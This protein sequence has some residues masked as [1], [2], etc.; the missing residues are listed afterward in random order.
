MSLVTNSQLSFFPTGRRKQLKNQLARLDARIEGTTETVAK[1]AAS[2]LEATDSGKTIFLNSA[3]GFATT[4]PAPAAGL[5]FKFVVSTAPTSGNHTI[6]T[7]GSANIIQGSSFVS[8]TAGTGVPAVNE[9]SINLI[10][11]QAVAG[12]EVQVV[13]DGTNWYVKA[14][15]NVGAGC[16]FTA[17]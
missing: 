14:F 16:T 11:N 2:T 7:N 13:S 3:T 1:T 9:D 17:A 10:A 15:V 6:V 8:T 4:L 12:D 5:N